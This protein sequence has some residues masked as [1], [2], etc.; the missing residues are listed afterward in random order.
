MFTNNWIRTENKAILLTVFICCICVCMSSY[1]HLLDS[2]GKWKFNINCSQT[3]TNN[4]WKTTISALKGSLSS[5]ASLRCLAY[6]LATH[7]LQMVTAFGGASKILQYKMAATLYV[8]IPTWLTTVS[9]TLVI[10][11]IVVLF[12]CHQ[13]HTVHNTTYVRIIFT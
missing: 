3:S 7:A 8:C 4:C 2:V 11:V 10:N 9:S 1:R 13:C 12:I 5:F 6:L